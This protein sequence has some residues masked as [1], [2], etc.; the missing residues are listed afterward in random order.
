MDGQ[1]REGS[2]VATASPSAAALA[3]GMGGGKPLEE[4]SGRVKAIEAGF[5]AWI[6]KQPKHIE[7]AVA[8]AV[9]AVQD[10]ALGGARSPPTVGRRS[11]CRTRRPTRT[12]RPWQPAGHGI[13]QASP[14]A[15]AGGPLV[16]ARN[17]AVMTGANAGISCVMRRIRGGEDIQG[18]G[19]TSVLKK[20]MHGPCYDFVLPDGS[21]KKLNETTEER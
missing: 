4:W 10:R 12:R 21:F 14:V 18:S 6:A 1:K 19:V 15:L 11:P 16:Q 5:R 20:M 7:A 13:V 17:F 9:G 2:A 8:T 3:R